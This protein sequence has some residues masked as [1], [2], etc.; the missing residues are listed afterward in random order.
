MERFGTTSRLSGGLHNTVAV[1]QRSGPQPATATANPANEAERL[2]GRNSIL[3]LPMPVLESSRRSCAGRFTAVPL[4]NNRIFTSP[5]HQHP[6]H[7]I[8]PGIH[9]ACL[10][11]VPG[12]PADGLWGPPH[13]LHTSAFWTACPAFSQMMYD[14]GRF[15]RLITREESSD[16]QFH[17]LLVKA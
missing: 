1:G 5:R 6:Q 2:P 17:A 4:L 15:C 12:W 13:A 3:P 8:E 7:F 14:L 9:W 11:A 16:V 10:R